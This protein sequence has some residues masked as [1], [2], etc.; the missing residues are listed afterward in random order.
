MRHHGK[1]KA[2][3]HVI[4]GARDALL[5]RGDEALTDVLSIWPNADRQAD[6]PADAKCYRGARQAVAPS[7]STQP[8]SL[9]A[10]ALG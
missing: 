4:E 7:I 3:E 2:R 1:A 6:S 10:L 8:I 9:S 5:L